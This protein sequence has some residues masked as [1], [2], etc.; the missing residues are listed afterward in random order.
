MSKNWIQTLTN[1]KLTPLDLK[2]EQVG[3]IT[4]IAHSLAGN[5]RF[6]RQTNQRYSVAEHCVRGSQVIEPRLAGA[7]LLHELSEV[8][9]PDIASPL[10]PHVFVRIDRVTDL[11]IVVDSIPWKE[12]ERRHTKA[13]LQRFGLSHVEPLID[14][15]LSMDLAMLHAEKRDLCGPPPEPWPPLPEPPAGVKIERAWAPIDAQARFIGRFRQLF[16]EAI[17]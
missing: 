11:G 9:L 3:P 10:K 14:E 15:V 4:E 17:E 1:R 7:F 12:L 8:Y 13:I 5:F 2:P 6:T 16:P